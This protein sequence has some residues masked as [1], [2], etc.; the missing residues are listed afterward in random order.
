MQIN[1]I[2][3]AAVNSAFFEEIEMVLLVLSLEILLASCLAEALA[4]IP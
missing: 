3:V 4:F 2:C 1:L